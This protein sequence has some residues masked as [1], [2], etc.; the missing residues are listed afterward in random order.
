MGAAV[1]WTSLQDDA[2][3]IEDEGLNLKARRDS[4]F[5]GP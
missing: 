1:A 4:R 3:E 5:V 2:D